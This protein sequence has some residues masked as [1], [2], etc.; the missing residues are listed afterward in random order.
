MDDYLDNTRNP[1][2]TE[3]IDWF[4]R[5]GPVQQDPW[6]EKMQNLH[7]MF[8][9]YILSSQLLKQLKSD[10]IFC[11]TQFESKFRFGMQAH[12]SSLNPLATSLGYAVLDDNFSKLDKEK[13]KTIKNLLSG[14]GTCRSDKDC[15]NIKCDSSCV[16]YNCKKCKNIKSLSDCRN[17]KC[18]YPLVDIGSV[19]RYAKLWLRVFKG[20]PK[21]VTPSIDTDDDKSDDF[22][23]DFGDADDFRDEYDF[24]DADDFRDEYDF[25]DADDFRDEYDDTD[26]FGAF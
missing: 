10:K 21:P 18:S 15:R 6:V 16:S 4:S 2:S 25:G 11:G 3:E 7:P 5:V 14:G 9:N 17:S 23:D 24:G 22:R 26:D 12:L 20:S 19:V 8:A 1:G 13:I